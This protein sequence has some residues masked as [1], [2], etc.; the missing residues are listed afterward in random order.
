MLKK[1]KFALSIVIITLL[2][3]ACS[4]SV[5]SL[6]K[7]N[8]SCGANVTWTLDTITGKLIISGRGAMYDYDYSIE[9]PSLAP[10]DDSVASTIKRVQIKDG[11]TNIGNWAFLYCDSLTSVTIPNSVT[12]IGSEAFLGCYALTSVTIPN[13]VISIGEGAFGAC[14]SFTSITIPNSVTNIERTAFETCTGLTSVIIGSSVTN[15]G[16]YAFQNC[17]SLSSVTCL[18]PVPININSNVFE[19]APTNTCIL[20]VPTASIPLYQQAAGWNA[21]TNIVGM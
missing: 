20:K 19:N 21:F 10:W 18:N 16:D 2:F 11:I 4:K 5:D 7:I 1:F 3:A 13:S 8:G 17:N 12:S 9:P 14:C 6:N 15:I